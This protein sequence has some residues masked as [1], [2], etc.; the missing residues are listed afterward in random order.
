MDHLRPGLGLNL[1]YMPAIGSGYFPICA[2][3]GYADGRKATTLLIR[4]LCMLHVIERITDV[5]DWWHKVHKATA[6][7]Q[8]KQQALT[9]NW[10]L[11]HIRADF[12]PRMFDTCLEELRKKA[13]LYNATHFTPVLDGNFCVIKYD[14]S[15]RVGG[16][17][18]ACGLRLA[19]MAAGQRLEKDPIVQASWHHEGHHAIVRRLV[20]PSLWP[21]CYGQ[22]R[23]VQV[24]DVIHRDNCLEY[25]CLGDELP[26]PDIFTVKMDRYALRSKNPEDLLSLNHQYLPMEVNISENGHATI[27][28]Y[29]NNVHPLEHA[30]F[31]NT[32]EHCITEWLPAWD[33]TYRWHGEFEFQRLK[34][35]NVERRC[36]TPDICGN[37]CK[38]W[39]RPL[40]DSE[41]KRDISDVDD[42][43]G[44][45]N[46]F[47]GIYDSYEDTPRGKFDERWFN[48]THPIVSPDSFLDS[49]AKSAT[50]ETDYRFR[51]QKENIRQSG[52]FNGASG[53]QVIVE[54]INIQLSPHQ[55]LFEGGPWQTEALLNEHVCSTALFF[56]DD[57]NVTQSRLSFRA[58]SDKASAP[59]LCF[60]PGED[61]RAIGRTY[62]IGKNWWGW[63]QEIGSVSV[64]QGRVVVFPNILQ[65]KME[66]FSLAN[67]HASG[68]R[69]VLA[70]HLVDPAIPIISTANVAPQQ[71][72]WWPESTPSDYISGLMD[73]EDAMRIRQ[74]LLDERSIGQRYDTAGLGPT[75][76]QF[77][78]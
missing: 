75:L 40:D 27:E 8:W 6:V 7:Q 18:G 22:T 68:H 63:A 21:L 73:I 34:S 45:Y 24:G 64:T 19:V 57:E 74:E 56:Y 77:S 71:R 16:K 39:N 60:W 41:E 13:V 36:I 10:E 62:N 58:I 65:H 67:S 3:F 59:P 66:P 4:E 23:I 72:H 53:I 17:G 70:L 46:P 32:I 20:D 29:I 28:S 78:S 69:K 55:P 76:I 9:F 1:A 26:R 43:F 44:N 35:N 42:P 51:L 54:L 12:T 52:Y 49:D 14:R 61:W 15:W 50:A 31:Y 33:I 47:T 37:S 2:E 38:A 11:F 48:E 30:E 25:R 5:P